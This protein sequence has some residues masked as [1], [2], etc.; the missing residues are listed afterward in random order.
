MSSACYFDFFL[1]S[2][3]GID[4]YADP[5]QPGSEVH[6]VRQYFT[7][8]NHTEAKKGGAKNAGCIFCEKLFTALPEPLHISWRV[9]SW[10]KSKQAYKH[11]MQSTKRMMIGMEH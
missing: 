2:E 10:A 7:V 1:C 4:D 5:Q 11:V 6:Y 9:L 8:T 3:D